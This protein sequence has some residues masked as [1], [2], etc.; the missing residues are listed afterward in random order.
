MPAN[1]A[2]TR[3]QSACKRYPDGLHHNGDTSE[4]PELNFH[5]LFHVR[6]LGPTELSIRGAIVI[7]LGF[8]LK[9]SFEASMRYLLCSSAWSI[10][11]QYAE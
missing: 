2:L 3:L 9:D 6:A 5:F 10:G 4:H 7:L 1:G 11:P 8:D